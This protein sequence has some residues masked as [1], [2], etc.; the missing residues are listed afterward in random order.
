MT[1]YL[2]EELAS[3]L[4]EAPARLPRKV[5]ARWTIVTAPIGDLYVAATDEG[6]SFVRSAIT[7]DAAGFVD[8]FHHRFRRPLLESDKPPAGVVPAL[9]TGRTGAI[10]FDLRDVSAF[11]RDVLHA[12]Q[13]IPKGQVRPYA[14][15]AH[16][17]GRPKAV[18][19]VGSALHRNPVPVLIPCHRVVRS[20]GKVGDYVFGAP[21]KRRLLDEE[22]ANIDEM[23]S[24]ARHGVHYVA[25]D[26]TGVVCFPTCVD[27]RRI[28]PEHRHGFRTVAAAQQA[29]YRPC[30]HCRPV[31]AECVA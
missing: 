11:E 9:R 25:S 28:T 21:V 27:A 18:R 24:L 30:R 6:V 8:E 5:F 14:W 26:T 17:I 3:L 16:Q 4:A 15:V 29:G 23:S 19:A 1:D 10:R 2:V 22:G 31:A 7:I 13:S 12:V 20:D